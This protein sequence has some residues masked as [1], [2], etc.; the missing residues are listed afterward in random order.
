MCSRPKFSSC[1][2]LYTWWGSQ[3]K[4]GEV[5]EFF[6]LLAAHIP[7][8]YER[9]ITYYGAIT[10]AVITA[11]LSA[12]TA[13]NGSRRSWW[14]LFRWIPMRRSLQ[15]G[16]N[17]FV[18][19]TEPIPW[20]AAA[21]VGN[22][23]GSLPSTPTHLRSRGSLNTSGNSPRVRHSWCQPIPFPHSA[24][25]T[26]WTFNTPNLLVSRLSDVWLL[27]ASRRPESTADFFVVSQRSQKICRSLSQRGRTEIPPENPKL[28]NNSRYSTKR[29]WKGEIISL[30]GF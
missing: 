16:W 9:L 4:E 25:S 21:S 8:H 22:Q 24:T 18:K 14:R 13:K 26:I 15:A 27:K 5:T 6:V 11:N 19:S 17:G 1:Q 3:K 12:K 10:S 23:C 7:C 28:K 29:L 2:Q 30:T 20:P